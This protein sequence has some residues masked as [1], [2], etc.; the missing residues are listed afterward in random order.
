MHS[1]AYR[2]KKSKSLLAKAIIV[3]YYQLLLTSMVAIY[4]S[5]IF[6]WIRAHKTSAWFFGILIIAFAFFSALKH[7]PVFM[8]GDPFYHAKVAQLMLEHIAIIRD[9]PW[10]PHS[11]L[12]T[13]YYDHHFLFHIFLIPFVAVIHDPLSAIRV[14]TSFLSAFFLTVFYLFFK[15]LLPR[16]PLLPLFLVLASSSILFR[17]SLDK[18]PAISLIV[19]FCALYALIKRKRGALFIVSFLYVWLYNAWPLLFIAC[20]LF[21][22]ADAFSLLIARAQ[23]L[24]IRAFPVKKF[25][26]LCMRKENLTLCAACIG[27]LLAGII[28]NP[29][30]PQ[31][32]FFYNTHLLSIAVVTGGILYGIGNEWLPVNPFV[33]AGENT[34]F[35]ILWLCAFCWV[36]FQLAPVFRFTTLSPHIRTPSSLSAQSLFFFS[37]S[38]FLFLATIKSQRMGEYFIPIGSAFIIYA[39][40]DF[41]VRARWN[42]WF[43]HVRALFKNTSLELQNTF[44][45][46]VGLSIIAL[47]VRL[48]FLSY[49]ELWTNTHTGNF[50]FYSMARAGAFISKNIPKNSLIINDNWSHF[51][52][53]MYYA[54]T[55]VFAW[56]L[57]P[58]F[59]HDANKDFFTTLIS[60]AKEENKNNLSRALTDKLHSRYLL[61][62]KEFPAQE[63]KLARMARRDAGLEKIYEDDEA[64]IYKV[65]EETKK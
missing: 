59:T 26:S 25:F 55:H 63:K 4:F 23:E 32:V 48:F 15:K 39:L 47:C 8:D 44:C 13:H 53:L 35:F 36:L 24:S 16:M 60:L 38:F 3:L 43:L 42:E 45:F 41:F 21:C 12:H 50:P 57:D 27:G 46:M 33:F 34:L 62:A 54:D 61:I 17:L 37:F 49:T 14:A 2:A 64:L 51:P 19:L 56:G 7:E 40:N 22:I 31:N 5:T 11:V 30:F 9:F 6:S 18:A 58:T 29:Y 10:L 28:I 1:I 65:K 20:I 52:Q